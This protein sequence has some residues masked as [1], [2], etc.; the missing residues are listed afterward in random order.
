M[1]NL[2]KKFLSRD[3]VNILTYLKNWNHKVYSL[4]DEINFETNLSDFFVLSNSCYKIEFIAEN[5]RSLITGRKIEVTHNFIFFNEEGEFLTS[6]KYC[7]NNFYEKICLDFPLK[8]PKSKYFSF[9]H[10]VDSKTSL[11]EIFE[12]FGLKKLN[13]I[14]EQNRGYTVYYPEENKYSGAVVHGNFGGISKNYLTRVKT[15]FRKHIYTPIYK[16]EDQ[17]YYDLVFNNPTNKN[18][19]IKIIFNNTD[20]TKYLKIPSLGTKYISLSNY[21]GS[22]SFESKLA[23]CRAIIFKNP[24]PNFKGN[25]DVFHS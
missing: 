11:Y 3:F 15:N 24:A 9:I 4:K 21:S 20:E 1:N 13:N 12:D 8:Y 23:I 10:F 5:L 14:C 6:Q 19:V 18:L 7:T 25:F 2:L 16:F 22:L 17:E